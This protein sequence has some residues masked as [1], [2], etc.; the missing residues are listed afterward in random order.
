MEGGAP[1]M[2]R[3]EEQQDSMEGATLDAGETAHVLLS[4]HFKVP[5]AE[6]TEVAFF[7][8]CP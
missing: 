8:S 5:T 6:E 7:P 4:G 2:S 3:A 1:Q